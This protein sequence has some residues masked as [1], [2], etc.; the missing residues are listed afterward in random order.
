MPEADA[1][2][3]NADIRLVV[4]D[5]GRVFLRLAPDWRHA[6]DKAQ[7]PYPKTLDD[8]AMQAQI[9]EFIKQEEVG[10]LGE[11]GFFE[12]AAPLLQ[13]TPDQYTRVWD[14]YLCGTFPG[15]FELIAELANL[16][17]Q[18]ACFS[19]TNHNH[20]KDLTNPDHPNGLPLHQLTH[21]FA[22]Q[23]VGH[24]KPDPGIYEHLEMT[25]RVPP[26]Q[27]LFFD[28]L[29]DNIHTASQRGWNTHRVTHPH[30]TIPEIRGVLK[31]H[32]VLKQ[33]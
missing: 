28:D 19:N 27:I 18:T 2:Q 30:D 6:F 11:R 26:H 8:P 23:L 25:T 17:I 31:H 13:L 22:S 1:H 29:A 3:P 33:H 16:P 12:Q 7:V 14:A 9:L 21:Q 10:A 5:L 15:S 24:R 20:W 32:G 4:F